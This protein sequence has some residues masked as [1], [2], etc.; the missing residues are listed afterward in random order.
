MEKPL[1]ITTSLGKAAKDQS[2]GWGVATEWIWEGTHG[3]GSR[4]DELEGEGDGVAWGEIET[5]GEKILW[6]KREIIDLD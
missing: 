5:S 2:D 6:V 4:D 1:L 3:E